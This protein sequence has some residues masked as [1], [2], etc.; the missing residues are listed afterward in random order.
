V[1]QSSLVFLEILK[2]KLLSVSLHCLSRYQPGNWSRRA[3]EVE[4]IESE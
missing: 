3:E 1:D 4:G 2:Q